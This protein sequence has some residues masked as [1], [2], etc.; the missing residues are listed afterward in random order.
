[1]CSQLVIILSRFLLVLY[2]LLNW[3]WKF[4]FS[5][6]HN[7]HK[8]ILDFKFCSLFV[9]YSV[10]FSCVS[11][12]MVYVVWNL[13]I[14]YEP[15]NLKKKLQNFFQIFNWTFA[16]QNL[17]FI[18]KTDLAF[19]YSKNYERSFSVKRKKFS[20]PWKIVRKSDKMEKKL[21]FFG[22]TL[23]LNCNFFLKKTYWILFN[24]TSTRWR[25]LL[26]KPL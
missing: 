4:T 19:F 2:T 22:T 12:S 14:I 24:A 5:T 13:F 1:M 16:T 23:I 9:L 15:T 26:V 6:I 25:S 17:C 21:K 11:L 8:L 18:V 7:K 3:F 20:L 10:F